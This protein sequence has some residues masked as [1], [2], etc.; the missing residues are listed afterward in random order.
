[1]DVD[2]DLKLEQSDDIISSFPLGD[3]I[4]AFVKFLVS[5]ASLFD[6]NYISTIIILVYGYLIAHLLRI[7]AV[8]S[9]R[10]DFSVSVTLH[11]VLEKKKDTV[12]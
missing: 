7:L 12:S 5:Q 2:G 9:H 11:D 10:A 3:M 8:G 6:N 1:M 4:S